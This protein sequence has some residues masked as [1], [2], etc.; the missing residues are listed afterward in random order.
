MI[1]AVVLSGGD[2]GLFMFKHVSFAAPVLRVPVM[3]QQELGLIDADQTRTSPFI[4]QD[5]LELE[6]IA[7]D[8]HRRVAV[9]Q[10]RVS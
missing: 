5:T 10:R 9:Y 1:R 8:P 3:Q 6:L 2:A 7:F 4:G